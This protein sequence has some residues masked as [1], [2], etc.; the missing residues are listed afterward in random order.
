M[1]TEEGIEQPIGAANRNNSELGGKGAK[2]IR[3]ASHAATRK[4]NQLEFCPITALVRQYEDICLDLT[5]MQFNHDGSVR[6]DMDMEAYCA[7]QN[8]RQKIG[9][10]LLRYGYS[11]IPETS[12]LQTVAVPSL[13]VQLTQDGDTYTMPDETVERLPHLQD[14]EDDV[15]E[16]VI[17]T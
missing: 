8:T 2:K 10:D 12:V 17:E 4:L 11:R 16:G 5:K 3:R 15:I 13:V 9:A 7:L 14:N 6:K 1:S